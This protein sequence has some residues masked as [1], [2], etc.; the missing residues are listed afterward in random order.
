METKELI[1]GP[2][3]A[4]V[5]SPTVYKEVDCPGDCNMGRPCLICGSTGQYIG[6]VAVQVEEQK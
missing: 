5:C 6:R 1:T 3:D 2:T 4:A